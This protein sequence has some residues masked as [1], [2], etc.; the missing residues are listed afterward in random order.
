M[1]ERLASLTEAPLQDA[2]VIMA[3]H[4]LYSIC[5]QELILF[6]DAINPGLSLALED[7]QGAH[8]D[9]LQDVPGIVQRTIDEYQQEISGLRANK[10][11]EAKEAEELVEAAHALERETIA[12]HQELRQLHQR[13]NALEEENASLKNNIPT[14]HASL[15][16][17]PRTP[18][19]NIA[20]NGFTG[21]TDASG[22]K[23]PLA[24]AD[25]STTLCDGR[26]GGG[27]GGNR[28][29]TPKPSSESV[30]TRV[31]WGDGGSGVTAD[32]QQAVA[33]EAAAAVTID[34]HR[35]LSLKQLHMDPGYPQ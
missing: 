20:T 22:R 14:G 6:A 30:T 10:E 31:A 21:A 27:G 33:V 7:L 13:L 32:G 12:H 28:G 34:D 25:L 16:T 26:G 1:K 5:F 18:L 19:H 24:V 29:M 4:G 8:H 23:P 17:R 15:L 9:L 2:E 11:R 3:K 35:E